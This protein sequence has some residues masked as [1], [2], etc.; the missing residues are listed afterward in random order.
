[1]LQLS[2]AALLQEEAEHRAR[3][4]AQRVARVLQLRAEGYGPTLIAERMGC[5]RTFVNKCL[6]EAA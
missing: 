4:K 1:M 2:T 6:R 3:L 5:S